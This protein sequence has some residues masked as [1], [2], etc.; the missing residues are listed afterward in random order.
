MHEFNRA[1]FFVLKMLFEKQYFLISC[2]IYVLYTVHVYVLGTGTKNKDNANYIK[3]VFVAL[4][5]NKC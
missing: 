5:K 1:E 2:S 3:I 4:K